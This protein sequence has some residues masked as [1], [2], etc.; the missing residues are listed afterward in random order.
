M[1]DCTVPTL[2]A[3]HPPTLFLHGDEDTVLVPESTVTLYVNALKAAGV[4]T[5]EVDDATSGH[6]WIPEAPT[7]VLA[8][9]QKYP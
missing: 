4:P 7:A 9:F 2:A 8:W 6:Q 1:S 5:S 3:T